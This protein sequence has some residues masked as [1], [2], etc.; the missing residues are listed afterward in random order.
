[1]GANAA[2]DSAALTSSARVPVSNGQ[3][4]ACLLE[5]ESDAGRSLVANRQEHMASD[6]VRMDAMSQTASLSALPPTVHSIVT[7]A[8][9]RAAIFAAS[10]QVAGGLRRH[11]DCRREIARCRKLADIV[12]P[13]RQQ[14]HEPPYRYRCRR[15]PSESQESQQRDD[16]KGNQQL[17]LIPSGFHMRSADS[18][19]T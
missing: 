19:A 13:R 2:A 12:S 6:R 17:P 7:P 9:A 4:S 5:S 16:T 18:H 3:P 10:P 8:T 14:W 11:D 1:M 15:R